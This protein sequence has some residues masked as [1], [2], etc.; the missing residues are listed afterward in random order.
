MELDRWVKPVKEARDA[1][2]VPK[3]TKRYWHKR[4]AIIALQFTLLFVFWLVLSGRYEA[5]YISIGALSAGL[6]TFLTNDLFYS[7][8]DRGKKEQ[9]NARHTFLQLGRFL[10]YLPWLLSRIIIANI[11]VAYLVLHPRMPIKPVLLQ[12]RTR[13]QRS[14]AQV[15]LGNSI[16]LTPGTVT[17]NLENGKY[18]IHVLV[19][20]LAR[21]L[22]EARMQNKIGAIFM[23]EKEPPP[24]ARWAYSLEELEE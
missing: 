13:L 9:I 15:I 23:E 1:F 24:A 18:T 19:P 4:L 7:L 21:E 20:P 22:L 12:F 17:V 6:V 8:F 3:A 2:Q 10:T 5:K 14:F 11:Q 16:T